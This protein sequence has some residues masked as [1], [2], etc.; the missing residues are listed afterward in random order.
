M[1]GHFQM[2][3]KK[4]T[5][6]NPIDVQLS[7]CLVL[8]LRAIKSNYYVISKKSISTK[9]YWIYPNETNV[10]TNKTSSTELNSLFISKR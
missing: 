2:F 6:V 5:K 1:S 9:C 4:Q 8:I 7:T 3:I 10:V